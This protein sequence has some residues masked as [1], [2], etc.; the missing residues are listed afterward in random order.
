VD[1]GVDK[2][3][4]NRYIGIIGVVYTVHAFKGAAGAVEHMEVGVNIIYLFKNRAAKLLAVFEF[5]FRHPLK[6]CRFCGVGVLVG[7]D[8]GEVC[9]PPIRAYKPKRLFLPLAKFDFLFYENP[10]GIFKG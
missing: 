8:K 2:G 7:E 4:P 9:V 1:I 10:V 5:R 3:F 6:D